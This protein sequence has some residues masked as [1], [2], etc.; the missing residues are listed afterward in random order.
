MPYGCAGMMATQVSLQSKT[1]H[2]DPIMAAKFLHLL[3]L[4]FF[5]NVF[6]TAERTTDF[7]EAS[8]DASCHKDEL[9][10]EGGKH[11]K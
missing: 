10:V 7:N 1:S 2:F 3:K 8:S 9:M 11:F 6:K 5:P 4:Q